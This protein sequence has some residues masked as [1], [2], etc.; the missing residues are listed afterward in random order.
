MSER[1]GECQNLACAPGDDPPAASVVGG[2]A[3]VEHKP[4]LRWQQECVT[5]R[6]DAVLAECPV[7]LCYNG[8]S[9]AVMMA[10]PAE[11]EDFALGFSLSEGIIASANQLYSSECKR[12]ARGIE[13]SMEIAA[14]AFSGL[15]RGRRQLAGRSGCGL[16]GVE[17]LD[18]LAPRLPAAVD[19]PVRIQHQAIQ[20]ALAALPARQSLQSETGAA[21]AA[22]WCDQHG[23]IHYLREDVGRHNA[24]DKL[25]GLHS[26]VG[27]DARGHGFVV[28]TSRAS[29][30]MVIKVATLGLPMLVA[31][32]APTTLA[33][34]YAL[35][36]NITLV[37]FARAG[38]HQIYAGEQRVC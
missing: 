33:V 12:H 11:L 28:I 27:G 36:T 1:A 25:L 10:T 22:A 21:H 3:A 15:K 32:S 37:G 23:D 19:S 29:Y 18:Q 4:A 17:S 31:V 6:S 38:R 35:A 9:H 34:D 5:R 16:C 24:L 30:E 13:L 20:R 2:Q 14:Q 26:R 7:A 8:V